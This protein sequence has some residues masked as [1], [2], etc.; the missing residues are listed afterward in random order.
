MNDT[1]IQNSNQN[2][3]VLIEKFSEKSEKIGNS[4]GTESKSVAKKSIDKQ[5]KKYIRVGTDYYKITLAPNKHG[6]KEKRLRKWKKETIKDDFATKF[7]PKPYLDVRVFESFCNIPDNIHYKRVHK[8]NWNIYEPLIHEV[9]IGECPHTLDFLRHIFG[10]KYEV[11]L[12]YLTILYRYPTQILPILCLVSKERQTGKTTFLK[13]LQAIFQ[14][15]MAVVSNESIQKNFNA[16]YVNKL[17]I[18]IDETAIGLDKKE[19][20]ERIKKM[21]TDDKA[22]IEFKGRDSELIDFYGKIVMCSNNETDF[23]Q[24]DEQEIRYFVNQVKPFTKDVINRELLE[25]CLI[26]EIPHFLHLLQTREITHP[27]KSRAWFDDT[28]IK[29][30]ALSKVIKETRPAYQIAIDEFIED[31]FLNFDLN[32]LDFQVIDICQ[33]IKDRVRFLD[34]NRVRKYLYDKG[35]NPSKPKKFYLYNLESYH[36]SAYPEDYRPS[37]KTGRCLTFKRADWVS[38]DIRKVQKDEAKANE[39]QSKANEEEL[40]F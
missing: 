9:K 28:V 1:N 34:Y 29:T 35:L 3:S 6:F 36:I 39:N 33:Q 19:V 11:G 15:N 17:I 18:A 22:F 4:N 14:Q 5:L 7:N 21:A 2:G 20:A 37:Y 32:E 8:G 30:E 25:S 40:P 31:C 16:H 23:I 38:E 13:W 12:D 10:E 26:P 24:I 27:P